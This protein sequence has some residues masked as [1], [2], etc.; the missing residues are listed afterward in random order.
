M[1]RCG[2]A[3]RPKTR[4]MCRGDVL[5]S[6]LAAERRSVASAHARGADSRSCGGRSFVFCATRVVSAAFVVGLSPMDSRNRSLYL[7]AASMSTVCL[8][9]RTESSAG[10]TGLTGALHPSCPA[11]CPLGVC[12]SHKWICSKARSRHWRS[13]TRLRRR[14]AWARRSR[15]LPRIPF[16]RTP[17]A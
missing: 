11:G 12:L 15:W 7:M 14:S 6:S 3:R 5:A 16:Y 17:A 2:T 9:L 1:V 8:A 4:A 10:G 13:W